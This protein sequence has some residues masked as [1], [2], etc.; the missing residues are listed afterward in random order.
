MSKKQKISPEE[1]AERF[2]SA[3]SDEEECRADA[4]KAGLILKVNWPRA[5]Q[6][7]FP[8]WM[9]LSSEDKRPVIQFWPCS[10]KYWADDGRRGTTDSVTLLIDLAQEILAS[11]AAR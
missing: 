3:I 5:G 4:E 8:H 9:F 11:R 6:H 1:W 2:E 10:R 7:T